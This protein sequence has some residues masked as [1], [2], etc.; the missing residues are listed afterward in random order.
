V[1]ETTP[2]TGY[3]TVDTEDK[4]KAYVLCYTTNSTV[5]QGQGAGKDALYDDTENAITNQSISKTVIFQKVN[6][7]DQA[8]L[9][10]AAFTLYQVDADAQQTKLMNAGFITSGSD[11]I[12]SPSNFRLASG[13]YQLVETQ[14][15]EGYHKL[16]EPIEIT[17]DSNGVHTTDSAVCS[18]TSA[19]Q[20]NK[21]VYTVLVTNTTGT[22]LPQTG[23]SGTAFYR[24]LGLALLAAAWLW[25]HERGHVYTSNK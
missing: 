20:D 25:W 8:P 23:G 14:A 17:V 5:L 1:Q 2:P 15:P 6:A 19:T 12:F 10:G 21:T 24:L 18:I 9:A 11:G 7:S 4:V 13:T 22:A 16:V 3:Q